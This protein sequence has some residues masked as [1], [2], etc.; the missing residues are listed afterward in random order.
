MIIRE[1][2]L[3]LDALAIM[4]G[5]RDFAE[6]IA[7]RHLLP[8]NDEEF[9]KAVGRVVNTVGVEILLAEHEGRVVGGIGILYAPFTWNLDRIVADEVFW[10][11]AENAPHRTGRRLIDEVMKRIDEK[12]AIP[13][14][15][16]LTTSPPGVEHVYRD[17][18][19][20]PIETT[21]TRMH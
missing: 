7:F 2:D 1:A 16:K 5:A 4:D 8:D 15:R 18:G 13:M 11:A 17:L 9:V 3:E 20:E 10:W 21:F 6:R 14:F 19:L 12:N